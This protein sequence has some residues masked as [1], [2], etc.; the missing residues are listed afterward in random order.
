MSAQVLDLAAVR[1]AYPILREMAYFN[2]GTYG[3]MAEPVLAGYLENLAR[4][5]R[6]GMAAGEPLLRDQIQRSRERI[7]ERVNASS[8]E[9]A[10]SGNATDGVAFVT[11]GLEWSPG[12]EVIISDQEHPAMNYPWYYTVQR[13]G[14]VVNRYTVHHD[15]AE[16]LA[17]VRALITPKTRLIGTSHVTSP[18][19]IRLPV[20]EICALAHAHGALAFVDGAQSFGVMPIDVRAID[21]DFFTSNVHKWLGGP[22]GTGFLYARQEWMERLH[23]A[24]V[25]ADSAQKFS[26]D[27]GLDLQPNGKRFEF[28]TRGFAVHASIGLALDWFDQVGWDTISGRIQQLS[29][30]LKRQLA[31]VPGV[32][33]LTPLEWARS[34]GLVSFRVVGRDETALQQRFEAA[35]LYPRTLGKAS[36]KIRVSTALFNDED[37]ID[38]LVE[39]VRDFTASTIG[40]PAP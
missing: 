30:R 10:L 17:A 39:C 4:F 37:E 23:P 19:G 20:K 27:A 8:T 35:R 13:H 36:E 5:E 9:I 15:P 34:S 3:I 21:C 6:R 11:A 40:R 14:I 26:F 32:E 22:K 12:D 2:T 31:E 38:H 25:G 1:E 16:S 7:A 29:S 28:G 18:C 33:V 24:Y